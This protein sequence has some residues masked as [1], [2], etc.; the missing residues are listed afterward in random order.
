MDAV[1]RS[2][3]ETFV[4]DPGP[5]CPTI[6]TER[7]AE[8]IGVHRTIILGWLA[9]RDRDGAD[10]ARCILRREGGAIWWNARALSEAGYL[11]PG[12]GGSPGAGAAP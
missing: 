3:T 8:R 5:A 12:Q 9:R 7:F 11:P 1:S 2:R 10:L 4:P 6:T